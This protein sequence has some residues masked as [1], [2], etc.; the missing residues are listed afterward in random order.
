MKQIIFSL[1]KLLKTS[2]QIKRNEKSIKTNPW[3]KLN[4]VT[5]A[6]KQKS[7]ELMKNPHLYKT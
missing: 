3:R 6:K 1:Q 5:M 7:P 2:K 4:E